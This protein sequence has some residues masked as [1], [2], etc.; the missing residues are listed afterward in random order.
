MKKSGTILARFFTPDGSYSLYLLRLGWLHVVV[1]VSSRSLAP[2]DVY[3]VLCT[4]LTR[5]PLKAEITSSS[6]VCAKYFHSSS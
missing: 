6:L 4:W 3:P 1:F 5:R 2:V